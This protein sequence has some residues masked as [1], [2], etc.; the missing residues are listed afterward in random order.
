LT[1]K[2]SESSSTP[3][4]REEQLEGTALRIYL[5]LLENGPAGPR[6][7]ARAL[8]VSPSTAHRHLKRLAE[9]GLVRE[10]GEGYEVVRLARIEGFLYL[11]RRLVPRLL[12]YSGFYAG[13][14]LGWLAWAAI[15]GPTPE[16][17]LL[18]ATNGLASALTALEGLA[19]LRRLK[20]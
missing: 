17:L 2:S 15:K 4:P 19:A 10:A 8:G 1:Q 18:A 9:A 16:I 13:L 14:T 6:Q 20:G 5:Y 3:S 7:V 12:V 11:G